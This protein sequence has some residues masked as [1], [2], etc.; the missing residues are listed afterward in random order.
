MRTQPDKF[1]AARIDPD[2]TDDEVAALSTD[3]PAVE[4][5][6][7]HVDAER[8]A[9]APGCTASESH[10]LPV[11]HPA[12]FLEPP[13]S[14]VELCKDDAYT[15]LSLSEEDVLCPAANDPAIKHVSK[16][17]KQRVKNKNKKPS[18]DK[19]ESSLQQTDVV[20]PEQDEE[21]DLPPCG[22][23]ASEGTHAGKGASEARALP[24]ELGELPIK[25]MMDRTATASI[26]QPRACSAN[27]ADRERHCTVSVGAGGAV[28]LSSAEIPGGY[29][30]LNGPF[31]RVAEAK[32]MRKGKG[33]DRSVLALNCSASSIS[34]QD[35][36][37][38]FAVFALFD[39]HGGH[40]AAMYASKCIL[41]ILKDELEMTVA[42][43][44]S[45]LSASKGNAREDGT[46][47]MQ[48]ALIEVCV[49][50]V[51]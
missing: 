42:P 8:L 45:M 33:E 38:L 37:T 2:A 15:K 34:S 24:S 47:V 27:D 41:D 21:I 7:L 51:M 17:S 44:L 39:G 4:T 18:V 30:A 40:G 22:A 35:V 48:E 19:P 9:S 26:P 20:S 23:G 6:Q 43:Q 29:N 16:K 13:R 50:S 10:T 28:V 1:Y 3:L 46:C 5:S 36:S 31:L 32:Q 14:N 11:D 25:D 12:T 49:Y